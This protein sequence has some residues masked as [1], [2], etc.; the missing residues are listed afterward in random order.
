LLGWKGGP[1]VAAL[2]EGVGPSNTGAQ[3]D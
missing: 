2:V 1:E 3:T